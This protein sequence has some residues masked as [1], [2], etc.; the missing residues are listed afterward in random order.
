MPQLGETVTEGTITKWMKAVGEE[1]ARDEPLFEV[2]TDKVDS[3]VPSPAAGV[4]SEILVPEGETVEV[5]VR[6]AVIGDGSGASGSSG[7]PGTEAAEAPA[8]APAPEAAPPAPAP[9]PPP[10]PPPPAQA[11]PPPPPPAAPAPASAP[12]PAAE[13]PPVGTDG[14]GTGAGASVLSPMVRRILSENDIDESEVTGT[15][16][17]GR[18]TRDDALRAADARRSA[19]ATAA[20]PPAVP[21]QAAPA[22]AA[23]AAPPARVAPVAPT[24]SMAPFRTA[25]DQIVPF[26]NMRRRTAEHMVRSKAT[27]PHAF[28]ANEVDFE[29][30]ERVRTAWGERFK[31]EEG[32]SL[33]YLPF[34]ARAAVEALRDFPL[35]NASVV[36]DSLV[37]HSEVNLGI[38]VDLSHDGLIVPVIHRA[39]EVTLRGVAR[40]IRDLAE[41]ARGRQLNADDI[42]G[43]TFSITND[44]PF[45]TYFTVPIINQP[46]VA[47]LATDGIARRPVVVTQA[48]GSES[49]AIHS[50]GILG[51]SWDHRAVDG[52]YVSL[53]LAKVAE[54][55]GTRDWAAEL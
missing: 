32:F 29:A 14:N 17:G 53:F 12:A 6:L 2:S 8:P 15:G 50:T 38:A 47:I 20:P 39:E 3:E 51:V 10:P 36:E 33:T 35:L 42:A 41:R 1:V 26:S 9:A 44:G 30:V 55:L 49:I 31:A 48:D 24:V 27:S 11:A 43:G 46:Q 7:A 28:I 40:R 23:P 19:G 52:A 22:Q 16:A 54:L 4:L 34:V 18:I 5:G 37:V 45:G 21:T 25:G 13:P